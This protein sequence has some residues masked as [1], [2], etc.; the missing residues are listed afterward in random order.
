MRLLLLYR[1]NSINCPWRRPQQ[2][3]ALPLWAGL[4]VLNG[5]RVVKGTLTLVDNTGQ[6][7]TGAAPA[8]CPQC[9]CPTIQSKMDSS[10]RIVNEA[11]GINNVSFGMKFSV[12]HGLLITGN[13][14][15]AVDNNGL[16]AKVVPLV[17]VSYKF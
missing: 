6:T 17:G 15:I 16:R 8:Q 13:A 9:S 14:L 10:G 11:Y 3:L 2:D 12:F 4:Y 1:R 7:P 5:P